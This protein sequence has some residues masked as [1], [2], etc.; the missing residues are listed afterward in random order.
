M[1]TYDELIK[2]KI[3]KLSYQKYAAN[4]IGLLGSLT[5]V[6]AAASGALTT[7]LYSGGVAVGG[8][9]V[10]SRYNYDSQI[11]NY[12]LTRYK[13]NCIYRAMIDMPSPEREL[14]NNDTKNKGV[15]I[16]IIEPYI[17]NVLYDIKFDLET[18]QYSVTLVTPD[19]EQLTK[20]IKSYEAEKSKGTQGVNT[21]DFN[22]NEANAELLTVAEKIRTQV[23][24]CK[25]AP[26]SKP[27]SI[28]AD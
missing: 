20:L 19:L 11:L 1:R 4:E 5:S 24:I 15:I 9:I 23:G 25:I 7:A 26:T 17:R 12:R 16:N 8:G 14:I 28:T 13:L 3:Q 22:S 18:Q 6:I 2:D 27:T 21:Y 10:E